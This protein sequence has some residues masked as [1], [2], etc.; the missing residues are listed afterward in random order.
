MLHDH[1][2]EIACF[3]VEEGGSAGALLL[4]PT[5]DLRH[6]I[7]ATYPDTDYVVLL[8]TSGAA[9]ALLDH[10]P[11]G[12]RLV[13]KLP[14]DEEQSLVDA[15]FCPTAH[16]RLCLPYIWAEGGQFAALER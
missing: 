7:R 10:I 15:A 2:A 11:A 14:G 16:Y 13:F 1:S 9:A 12:K 3:Y 5:H 6:S 4:L 8:S